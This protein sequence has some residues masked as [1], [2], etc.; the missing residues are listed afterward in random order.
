MNRINYSSLPLWHCK[1]LPSSQNHPMASLSP[2]WA[3]K[4]SINTHSLHW[5]SFFS[6]LDIWI[7]ACFLHSDTWWP[8]QEIVQL[9]IEYSSKETA[10][11]IALQPSLSTLPV[12]FPLWRV[13]WKSKR[14]DYFLPWDSISRK[15]WLPCQG[16]HHLNDCKNCP[17]NTETIL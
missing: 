3:A 14:F 8:L 2:H 13:Q 10:W 9:S 12:Q 15:K 5:S 1:K 17:I 16:S 4:N 7:S 6:G 11:P